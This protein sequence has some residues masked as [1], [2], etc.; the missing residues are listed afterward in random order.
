MTQE[1]ADRQ[2]CWSSCSSDKENIMKTIKGIQTLVRYQGMRLMAMALATV[3]LAGCGGGND[4]A[5]SMGTPS[6]ASGLVAPR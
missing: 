6:D 3:I 5:G 2:Q 4:A 1:N